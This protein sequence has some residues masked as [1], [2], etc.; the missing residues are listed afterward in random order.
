MFKRNGPGLRRGNRIKVRS[1]RSE[2]TCGLPSDRGVRYGLFLRRKNG[3]W[4]AGSCDVVAPRAMRR[5]YEA[6]GS[7]S[8]SSITG[9]RRGARSRYCTQ[10]G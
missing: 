10:P 3:R 9:M 4:T 1:A 2:A 5:L 6:E 8:A 7:G